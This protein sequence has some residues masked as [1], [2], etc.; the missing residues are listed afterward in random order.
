M[1]RDLE[2]GKDKTIVRPDTDDVC[3]KIETFQ[4]ILY[5]ILA[6]KNENM[7]IV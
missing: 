2:K 6:I 7:V 4:W 1:I 5:V 3:T